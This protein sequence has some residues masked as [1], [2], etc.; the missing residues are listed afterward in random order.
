MTT[1][2]P[3]TPRLETSG[4]LKASE[5][6]LPCSDGS[7]SVAWV[8]A[9]TP[10]PERQN[11]T[12]SPTDLPQLQ[13]GAQCGGQPLP[14][15]TSET[16]GNHSGRNPKGQDAAFTGHCTNPRTLFASTES[17]KS[18]TELDAGCQNRK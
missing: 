1:H 10:R 4:P 11:A 7:R 2:H 5:L 3:P 17:A 18:R 13:P 12:D 16:C 15:P 6:Q 9:V 8:R 14:T